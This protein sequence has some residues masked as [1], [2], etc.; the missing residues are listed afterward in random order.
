MTLE[1]TVYYGRY[2]DKMR[3]RNSFLTMENTFKETGLIYLNGS[4][5]CR[6]L[7]IS[8]VTYDTYILNMALRKFPHTSNLYTRIS[9]I[10]TEFTPDRTR[11]VYKLFKNYTS[12]N[13]FPMYTTPDFN[14]GITFE[15]AFEPVFLSG[16]LYTQRIYNPD[17]NLKDYIV[18][19]LEHNFFL[20]NE[21]CFLGSDEERFYYAF[22]YYL[23]LNNKKLLPFTS[24][25]G[26][27]GVFTI[28]RALAMAYIPEIKSFY[29][30]YKE[31]L[32]PET[33]INNIFNNSTV[34]L[35][36]IVNMEV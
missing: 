11:D 34:T 36:S 14:I 21:N 15:G 4:T 26:G 13:C 29:R 20:D 3:E 8:K 31:Y 19:C 1:Y 10:D 32:N 17:F 23:A 5:S 18:Y 22:F 27:N 9:I 16:F 6:E 25:N 7:L 30:D 33:K 35:Q 28:L 24:T 12:S 2:S